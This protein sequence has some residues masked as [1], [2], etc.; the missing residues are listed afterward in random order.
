MNR[1][2]VA[3]IACDREAMI[4]PYREWHR[5]GS[6]ELAM[7]RKIWARLSGAACPL[8]SRGF[9]TLSAVRYA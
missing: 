3:T 8:Y 2:M 1:G 9:D 5:L 7:I 4:V 6:P